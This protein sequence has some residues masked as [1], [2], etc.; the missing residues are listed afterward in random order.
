M[1]QFALYLYQSS[2]CRQN[3]GFWGTSGNLWGNCGCERVI[4]GQIT[5]KSQVE[6]F[7]GLFHSDRLGAINPQPN[8]KSGRYW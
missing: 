4:D 5:S 2:L 8:I 1:L 7:D 6:R 3:Q